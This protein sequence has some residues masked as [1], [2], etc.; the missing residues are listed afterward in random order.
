MDFYLFS[1]VQFVLI[2]E[3]YFIISILI[4]F[5]CSVYLSIPGRYGVFSLHSQLTCSSFIFL[6]FYLLLLLSSPSD[7]HFIFFDIIMSDNFVM[8]LQIIVVLLSLLFILI[9]PTF[10]I[11]G[12]IYAFEFYTL[13]LI[14]ILGLLLM[15]SFIDVVGLYLSIELVSMCFYLLTTFNKHDIYSNEA[16]LKYFILGAIS[17]N[18]VLFGFSFLYISTGMTNILG[19]SKLLARYLDSTVHTVYIFETNLLLT[20]VLFALFFIF[21]GLFFKI[22]AAPFHLWVSDIY[23]GSPLLI[24]SLFSTLP[25]IPFVSIIVRFIIYFNMFNFIWSYFFLFFA[26][27]S[28]IFGAVAGLFQSKMRRLLAYS[29]VTHVGYFCIFMYLFL[30]L[31]NMNVYILQ[32]LFTYLVVYLFSNMG[33]FSI[34]TNLYV[35]RRHGSFYLDELFYLSRLYRSNS[36]L[37]FILSVFLFSMSGLPPLPGFLGKLFLFSSI[38]FDSSRI[39]LF[40]LIVC[41]AVLSSFYY[42]RIIK[43]MYFNEDNSNWIFF[44]QISCANSVVIAVLFLFILHFFFFPEFINVFT[45]YL[46]L[47]LL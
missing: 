46:V 47:S 42:L 33:I 11:F 32:L 24:T 23:Q 21:I 17:S 28:I 9:S 13:I 30:Y 27:C 3:Y 15:I 40:I 12:R 41:M 38:F 22:Y 37:A 44:P 31:G 39:L 16:A 35:L 7:V 29:A 25:L 45:L 18:F 2:S 26:C 5:M 43:I 20:N 19:I 36:L 34:L 14:A 6:F 1:M 8:V 10:I 4:V